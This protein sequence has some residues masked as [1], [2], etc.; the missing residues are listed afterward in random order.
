MTLPCSS[1]SRKNQKLIDS[2]ATIRLALAEDFW[3]DSLPF[4]GPAEAMWWEVWLR[5]RRQEAN[6]VHLRF[7][8]IAAIVGIDRVSERYVSFPER[9]V[10]HAFATPRQLSTSVGLLAMIAELRKAKELSTPYALM[11]AREQQEFVDAAAK[12]II[13]PSKELAERVHPRRGGQQVS[14]AALSGTESRGCPGCRGRMGRLRPR[15]DQHGTGMAGIALYGCLTEAMATV[16]PIR[17]RHRLESVKILPP[18][19]GLERAAGLRAGDPGCGS[20]RADPVP[21]TQSGHL[22]GGHRGRSGDGNADDLVGG[23]GRPKRGRAGR[24]P[25]ADAHLRGERPGRTLLPGIPVSR[26]E[27]GESGDRGPQPVVER[28]DRRCLHR[29]SFHRTGGFRGLAAHSRERGPDAHEPHVPTM[30]GRKSG[31]LAHQARHRDGGREL[32]RA[33]VGQVSPRRS[34]A[35]DDDPAPFGP[36]RRDDA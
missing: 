8:E 18:P 9:V 17:L 35:F 27:H 1:R 31:R 14:S 24:D 16:E 34:L 7:V 20:H 11:P 3:Q 4:P 21:A 12:Q 2:V 28:A 30:A 33:G 26:V 23:G 32:R 29:E 15:C 25:E 10:L 5:G 13:P 19:A 36:A 6:E 22:H